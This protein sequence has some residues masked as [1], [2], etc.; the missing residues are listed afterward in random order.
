MGSIISS[1]LGQNAFGTLHSN[2]TPTN[3]VYINPSS[4]LDAKVW[5]DINIVG[6]GSYANNSLVYLQDQ[7]WFSLLRDLNQVRT[8]KL[9]HWIM[10]SNLYGADLYFNLKVPIRNNP[11]CKTRTKGA[12]KL[13]QKKVDVAIV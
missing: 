12:R 13:S 9:G 10:R 11:K 7:S 1:A 2:F 6:A 3:S 8:D 5:L 4:T